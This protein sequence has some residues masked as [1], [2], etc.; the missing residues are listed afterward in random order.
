MFFSMEGAYWKYLNS[1]GHAVLFTDDWNAAQAQTMSSFPQTI[2][3][4]FILA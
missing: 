2:C 4:L 3:Q 1:Y